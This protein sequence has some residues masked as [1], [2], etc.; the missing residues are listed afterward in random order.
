[1]PFKFTVKQLKSK[2]P[3]QDRLQRLIDSN[4]NVSEYVK[5]AVSSD[6]L[7][8]TNKK[9]VQIYD[10]IDKNEV[11]KG[12][13]CEQSTKISDRSDSGRFSSNLDF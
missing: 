7:T 10:A 4:K 5:K 1:M 2:T 8:K 3:A 6:G 13:K 11:A 12:A 9:K